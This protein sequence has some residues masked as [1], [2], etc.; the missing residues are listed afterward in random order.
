MITNMTG[1]SSRRKAAYYTPEFKQR[2]GEAASQPGV[3][4]S[5][6]AQ[7]AGISL[8]ALSRWRRQ[9]RRL[10]PATLLP[11][12]VEADSPL[13]PVTQL[14]SKVSPPVEIAATP[15]GTIE[16]T[17]Q[18]ANIRIHGLVDANTLRVVLESLQKC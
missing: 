3:S 4:L 10:E 15:A 8:S 13:P 18:Q 6:I 17:L 16:I 9:Y 11:I 5:T 1:T 14:E 7:K 2:L 12:A